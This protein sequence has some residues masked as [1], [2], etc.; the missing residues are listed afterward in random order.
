[1]RV[2]VRQ[3]QMEAY[4]GDYTTDPEESKSIRDTDRIPRRPGRGSKR[5]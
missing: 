3:I 5:G 2:K 4:P 1:M